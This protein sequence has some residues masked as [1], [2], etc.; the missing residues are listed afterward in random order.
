MTLQE[1]RTNWYYFRA[2][3]SQLQNPIQYVEHGIDVTTH[4]LRIRRD[5]NEKDALDILTQIAYRHKLLDVCVIVSR[6]TSE[7]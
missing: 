2:L 3:A 5:I 6:P 1:I 4:E 7:S